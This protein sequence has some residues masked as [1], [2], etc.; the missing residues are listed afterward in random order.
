MK[1]KALLSI[2]A[3]SLLPLL[4]FAQPTVDFVLTN[5]IVEP[6]SIAYGGGTRFFLT[7]SA[8]HRV[9]AF[10]SDN[11]QLTPFAGVNGQSGTAKG[12]G[13]VARFNSPRGIVAARGGLIVADSANHAL[14][15]LSTTGTVS[16]V[17]E[18][19]GNIGQA[20]FTDGPAGIA[21][22]NSPTGLATDKTGNI[23][24][25]DTKNNA[26]RKIDLNNNVT[27]L[28]AGF[29]EPSGLTLDDNGQIFVADTK[30][31]A[32]KI[33]KPDNTILHLA[34]STTRITGTNDSYFA[35][36]ALFNSPG[37]LVWVGGATGLLVSDSANHTLRRIYLNP[38][39]QEFFPELSGYSV[40]TYAGIPRASGFVD[41]PLAAAKFNNP[42]GLAR[43]IEGGLFIADLG[44]RALRRIQTTRKLPRVK[45]PT[46]GYVTFVFDQASGDYL[47]VLVPFK[48]II[49][50]NDAIIAVSA[51]ANTETFFTT[52]P[53]PGLFQP[54]AIPVPNSQNSLSTPP[55][56]DGLTRDEVKPSIIDA[57]PDTTL[58]LVSSA[59]NRRPSDLVQARV[60]YKVAT[61]N[62][63][64][65][66]PASFELSCG[67][68]GAEIWYTLDGSVPTNQPP[69]IVAESTTITI[70]TS[71]PFVLRARG[72]RDN[73]KPSEIA[74]KNF[75]PTQF[76][77]NRMTLGFERGEA[78]SDYIASAGQKFYA[79]VTLS[80]LPNA[81]MY[82]L[83]FNV[84]VT[85][86]GAAPVVAPGAVGFQS[87]LQEEIPPGKK[88]FRTIP[89]A[90]VIFS[91]N[92][93]PDT[94]TNLQGFL[95]IA[96]LL[97][98][99]AA[100]NVLAVGWL[101]RGGATNFYNTL[102]QDLITFSIAHDTVF[103]KTGS[104]VVVGAYSFNVPSAAPAGES[105]Q[106]T[107]GRPSATSDGVG[108]PAGDVFIDAPTGGSLGA[109][110]I[111]AV[112]NI[113]IGQR[114]Y[115]VGDA[116]PFRWL[117]AGD[118]G[119]TN[120]LNDDVM[121]VFQSAV[122]LLDMPV[123]GSDFF[124]S[125]DS[126]CGDFVAAGGAGHVLR[127]PNTFAGAATSPFFDGS[128]MTINNIAFGDGILDVTD[129]Y[130]TF[131]RSLD[132]TLTWFQRF[133]TNGVLAAESVP[134]LFRGKPN[135]PAEQFSNAVLPTKVQ[136]V[137][138]P[139]V[140]FSSPDLVVHGGEALSVPIY[141]EVHGS[142]PLRV[143]MLSVNVEALDGSPALD[144]TIEF[145]PDGKLGEPTLNASRGPANFSGAWLDKN[146][147]GL[148]GKSQIGN[149]LVK[150]PANLPPKAA[151][152]IK[153]Q[154]A[155]G[156]PNGLASFPLEVQDGLLIKTPRDTSSFND[157]LPDSWR[158][159][160]FASAENLLSH[161]NADADGDGV[162]NRDEFKAGTN[163]TDIRSVL[164]AKARHHQ[165]GHGK[166]FVLRWPTSKGKTYI[167]ESAQNAVSTEW[168][169]AAAPFT[170][171][172]FD[173][174]FTASG[175]EDALHFFRVRLKE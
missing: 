26:I 131:R 94:V 42:S 126:C 53:T 156:S 93:P 166:G 28:S 148:H 123:V 24:V 27:T 77:A 172:G 112:K 36:D 2:A 160:F 96:N 60:Q 75:S 35:A 41:G 119:N 150:I 20:G 39:V 3:A 67:T 54:D 21:Q 144:E 151:Y 32:I 55:Y 102:V 133:W 6:H 88:V 48:D 82:S 80:V 58:K 138:L 70:V 104:K 95:P 4:S 46:I 100:A 8:T 71:S 72:F 174:E 68:A 114:K 107:L 159:R 147:A 162:S 85:N 164:H 16:V 49:F 5:G 110:E 79:P 43:D 98:T 11:G 13:F 87:M 116:A 51:E 137:E 38:I 122:Y 118:F 157:D 101:E 167:I 56:Q 29:S 25:A 129:V 132:P 135:S 74:T 175:D 14:R 139:G 62:V 125:M 113:T 84:T 83:Q 103:R 120:L 140:S 115:V 23:Y 64:G 30:N 141:A 73:Y 18:F 149:L 142:H 153:L 57:T 146:V 66:N 165:P 52:G 152:R 90:M 163:P 106:I 117:N 121:Q 15:F 34:G 128:D 97:S 31:H 37:A 78:S 76:Q 136:S 12:P 19:A 154:H 169:P 109:G 61:P 1:T 105:Y 145:V 111:N 173:M 86:N 108:G 171:T 63:L 81:R 22:F 92:P 130:V 91:T 65:D 50:N 7:D 33:L 168:A 99:N 143:A 158:L 89:P 45:N 44:N 134:N 10:D 161:A 40:E 155:S 124:D 9:L 69:S 17:S 170:G 127:G 59:D 47:S